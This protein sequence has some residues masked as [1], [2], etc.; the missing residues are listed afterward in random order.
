MNFE[1]DPAH[2]L[3]KYQYVTLSIDFDFRA[4]P[5]GKHEWI[6]N[7]AKTY[8]I[9]RGHFDMHMQMVDDDGDLIATAKHACTVFEHKRGKK[10]KGLH[11]L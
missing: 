1:K 3:R 11:S 6:L 2:A 8:K 7:R 10:N 9:H 5:N 4:D